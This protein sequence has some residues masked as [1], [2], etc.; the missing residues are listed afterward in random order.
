MEKKKQKAKGGNDLLNKLY[1]K[2][3]HL[4]PKAVMARPCN[5]SDTEARQEWIQRK[6]V[7]REFMQMPEP[8]VK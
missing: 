7:D 5:V 8:S 2:Y 1:E 4:Y 6:Y 3:L